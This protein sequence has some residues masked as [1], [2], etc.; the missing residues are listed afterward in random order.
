VR[1]SSWPT[2]PRWSSRRTSNPVPER[3][4]GSDLIYDLC[5]RAALRGHRVFLLGGPPGIAEEA[6][7]RLVARYPG[8]QVVGTACPS[9]SELQEPEVDALIARIRAARPDIL[10][11]ALGQPKGEFWLARHGAA[12]GV[13]VAAQVGATLE[14]V[15]GRVRR[16][17]K[18]FQK[19]GMEWA[20][21]IYTDPKRLGPR[22]GKNAVFLLRQVVRDR[23]RRR[24]ASL[25]REAGADLAL[26]T[27]EGA[28]A[29]P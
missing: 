21:R 26:T 27:G 15:A 23:I 3:V 10:F 13:P 7:R 11:A 29:R 2:A 14:F 22:Y 19:T 16:A 24:H 28:E 17:P 8:L 25:R 4:A 20:F 1:P 5:E 9:A 18:L 12:L 6:E